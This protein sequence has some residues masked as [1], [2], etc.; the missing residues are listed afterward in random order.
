MIFLKFFFML[1]DEQEIGEMEANLLGDLRPVT[2]RVFKYHPGG[3][4]L[5]F[6]WCTNTAT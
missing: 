6:F 1:R 3:L 5:V 2:I 4:K